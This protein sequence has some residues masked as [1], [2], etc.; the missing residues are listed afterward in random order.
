MDAVAQLNAALTGRYE[1]EREIGAG[2]VHVRYA[3]SDA[4]KMDIRKT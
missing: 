3:M 1:I 2:A 4:P